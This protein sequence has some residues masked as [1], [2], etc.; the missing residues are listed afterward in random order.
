MELNYVYLQ[1]TLLV[2]LAM[3][4][5][6]FVNRNFK[7]KDL[8]PWSIDAPKEIIFLSIGFICTYTTTS[9]D[10]N[11]TIKG[12]TWFIILIFVSI[13]VYALRSYC[14]KKYSSMANN[15]DI[16][17]KDYISLIGCIFLSFLSAILL[18]LKVIA[19]ALGG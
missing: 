16:K 11:H 14:V 5:D 9:T 15:D 17:I 7:G 3:G 4:L 12:T 8:I 18:Y 10:E 13:I 2:L 6:L 19:I 1:P